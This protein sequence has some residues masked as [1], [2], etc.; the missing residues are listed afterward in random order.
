MFLIKVGINTS[1]GLI[2]LSVEYHHFPTPVELY[3]SFYPCQISYCLYIK[4]YLV[5][6][7]DHYLQLLMLLV[8]LILNSP[9]NIFLIYHCVDTHI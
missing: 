3:L 7:H 5:R 8:V 1:T 9:W 4:I 6:P 2:R